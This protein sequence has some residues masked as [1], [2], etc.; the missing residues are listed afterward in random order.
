MKKK[1]FATLV[2]LTISMPALSQQSTTF[3]DP[4]CGEW[5][6]AQRQNSRYN[7]WLVGYM[8]GLNFMYDN[9]RHYDKKEPMPNYLGSVSS[10]Q[11]I[12]LW[13]DN[14]CQKNPLRTVG[15]AGVE[16]MVELSNK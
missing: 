9:L 5:I 13:V 15:E 2:A 10:A 3:G 7:A 6:A 1:L 14:Y 12:F 4:D 11:Q 8:S 16:L